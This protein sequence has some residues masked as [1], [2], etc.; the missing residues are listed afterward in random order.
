MELKERLATLR[1]S[2][3]YSLRELRERI[4][5]ESGE[6][7]SISYLSEL[8]R[9][10]GTPSMEVLTRIAAGYGMTV[11][12]LLAPVELDETPVEPLYSPEFK[13][14]ARRR[15]LDETEMEELW[16]VVYRGNRPE[17]EDDWDLLYSALNVIDNRRSGQ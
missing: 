11:R 13:S 8:E 1:R 15:G 2:R 7:M 4:E 16:R 10:G 5:R 3:K 17:T 12:D 6:A 14:F 9:R